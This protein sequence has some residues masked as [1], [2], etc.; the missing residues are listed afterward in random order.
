MSVARRVAWNTAVQAAARILAIGLALATL[1]VVT[2]HLGVSGYGSFTAATVY[3]ALFAV[4]FD[5]GIATILVRRLAQGEGDPAY[6][7]GTALTL[8]VLLALGVA[9]VAAGLSF[10]IYA[11]AA[12]IRNGI[13]I[14]LPT[15][16]FN[17]VATTAAVF[18][19]AELRMAWVA[20]AEVANQALTLALILVLVATDHGLYAIVGATVAGSGASAILVTTFLLR[21]VRVRPR[22]DPALWRR[23]FVTALPLGI[24]LVLNTVYF[25]LDALLLS[26]MKGSRDVGIYGVAFRF[27]EMLI[28]FAL[29]FVTSV[30]PLLAAAVGR[31]DLHDLRGL[32]QR[33]FDVV[34]VAAAPVVFGAVAIAPE[35]VHAIGGDAFADAALPLRIVAA[36]MGFTFVNALLGHVLVALDRQRDAL[37]LNA[38]ALVLNLALNLALIPPYGYTAAASVAASSEAAVCIGLVWLVHRYAGLWL[39]PQ[40]GARA[41]L[42]AAAMGAAVAAV[43]PN[44][45]VAVVLGAVVYGA[46]LVLLR[47]HRRIELGQIFAGGAS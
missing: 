42:V 18:F 41:V 1:I 2:R 11:D 43:H 36:G 7:L 24:A 27:S 28:P 31:G 25:R 26:V 19:Q 12:P 34:V 33:A 37:W 13:L 16:V 10:P 6:L 22:V 32:S 14:A 45:V 30:F 17:A 8:R 38:G 5:L 4:F 15:I 39:S 3:V 29:Y 35:I 23:L 40:T 20:I 47:I 44:I 21:H 46:G 9:A